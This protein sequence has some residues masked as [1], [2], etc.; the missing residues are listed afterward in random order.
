MSGRLGETRGRAGSRGGRAGV[1]GG[2]EGIDNSH[3]A[4][5]FTPNTTRRSEGVNVNLNL[6]L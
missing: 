4:S 5:L 6:C 2:H 3:E 1:C